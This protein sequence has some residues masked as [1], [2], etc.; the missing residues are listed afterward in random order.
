MIRHIVLMKIRAGVPQKQIDAVFAALAG[1]KNK[2]PGVLSFDGGPYSSKEGL[3]KGFTHGFAMDFPSAA[4][5]DRYLPHPEHEK[6]KGKVV[7][8]LDGGIDG[9]IAFDFKM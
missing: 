2:I 3:N 5:R 8:V 7:E 1:L 4:A 6:V 9:V